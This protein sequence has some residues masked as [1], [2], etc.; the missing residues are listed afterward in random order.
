M[1]RRLPND[2]SERGRARATVTRRLCTTAGFYRY[3]IEEELLDHFPA[4]HV[5]RPRLDYESH[6]TGL[7]RN[8]L[9][10]LPVAAGLGTAA[11]HALISLLAPNGLRVSEATSADIVPLA[12]RTAKATDL[13]IGERCAGTTGHAPR[14]T[15]IPP[16]SSLTW[17]EPPGKPGCEAARHP[18]GRTQAR[19]TATARSGM[20]RAW[21]GS[22]T[23]SV[24]I[25]LSCQRRCS[26]V[27]R[28]ISA[29][30]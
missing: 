6:T 12:P 15:G 23:D 8:E 26:L 11:E 25:D 3:A 10:A 22:Q 4:A 9:G 19:R 16:T 14:W 5:R 28:A 1:L 27:S 7:D 18:P 2:Q 17:R 30:L 29:S 13:A 20:C 21:E 24:T